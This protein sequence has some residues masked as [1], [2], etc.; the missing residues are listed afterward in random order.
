MNE[1]ELNGF[2][3]D[4]MR[5]DEPEKAALS[6]ERFAPIMP[7]EPVNETAAEPVNEPVTEPVQEAGARPE[8]EAAPESAQER[9]I[10]RAPVFDPEYKAPPV[11]PSEPE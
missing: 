7:P 2:E 3:Q 5:N 10:P 11:S 4:R 6:D 1:Y 9:Q 8:A